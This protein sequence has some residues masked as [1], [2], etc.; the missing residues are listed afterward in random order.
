M[1]EFIDETS[2]KQGTD[3]NRRNMMAIQ[4]FVG[5]V[6]EMLG[7]GDILQT[8]EN[9]ETLLTHK[10]ADGSITQ[11]FAGEKIITKTIKRVNGKIVEVIS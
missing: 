4:G 9:N 2:E 8:N 1:I 6:T 7:N 5:M 11:T 3:F 10:E